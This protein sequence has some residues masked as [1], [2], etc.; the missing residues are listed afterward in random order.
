[1]LDI[2]GRHSCLNDLVNLKNVISWSLILAEDPSDEFAAL[3]DYVDARNCSHLP[4]YQPSV[5]KSG[6]TQEMAQQAQKELK[7]NKV[8]CSM[9]CL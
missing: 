3:R 8:N 2:T 4:S 7:L 6:F 9:F 5:I 1:M